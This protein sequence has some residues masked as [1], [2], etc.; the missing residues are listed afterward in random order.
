MGYAKHLG[1]ERVDG[2]AWI[3]IVSAGVAWTTL[4]VA[5]LG[6]LTSPLLLLPGAAAFAAFLLWFWRCYTNLWAVEGERALTWSPRWAIGA[7][8][9]PGVNLVLPLVLARDLWRV[10]HRLV[11]RPASGGLPLVVAVAALGVATAWCGAQR[12]VAPT[13]A[14]ATTFLAL[15]GHYVVTVSRLQGALWRLTWQER[16][17]QA[18]LRAREVEPARHA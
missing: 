5:A 10:A 3:L 8:L 9:V 11:N 14:M 13:L 2:A 1:V 12:L 18:G 7:W 16:V 15:A 17:R 6:E 4:V